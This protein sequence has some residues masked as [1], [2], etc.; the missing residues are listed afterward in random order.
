M[1]NWLSTSELGKV[2]PQLPVRT[3]NRRCWSPWLQ[4][5]TSKLGNAAWLT[6]STQLN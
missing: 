2:N 6:S 4:P 1:S 3:T 5:S